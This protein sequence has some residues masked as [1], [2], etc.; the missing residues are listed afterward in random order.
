MNFQQKRLYLKIQSYC[1]RAERCEQ[2]VTEKLSLWGAQPADISGFVELLYADGFIDHGR[3]ARLFTSDKFRLQKW[4]KLK[5]AHHLK[6][7]GIA[8]THIEAAL[9]T[10]I[11]ADAYEQ[12]VHELAQKKLAALAETMATPQKKQKLL[13]YLLQKGYEPAMAQKELTRLLR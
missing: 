12:T 11:D 3:Y 6:A 13:Q 1:A 10:E 9:L 2:E 8:K 5:I 7:K 4:G